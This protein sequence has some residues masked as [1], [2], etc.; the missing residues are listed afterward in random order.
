MEVTVDERMSGE[1]VLRLFGRFE[2]LHLPFSSSRRPMRVLGPI[3]QI[4]ALPVLNVGKQVAPG[5]A[6]AAQFVGHDH[7]RHVL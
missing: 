3:V 5:D 1:K 2:P 4:L 6:V 7:P